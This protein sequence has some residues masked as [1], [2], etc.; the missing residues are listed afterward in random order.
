MTESNP[1]AKAEES[2]LVYSTSE[3]DADRYILINL[4]S[5]DEENNIG[6]SITTNGVGDEQ[7]LE[8][9]EKLAAQIREDRVDATPVSD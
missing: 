1:V 3:Q 6:V 2:G 9:L 4:L 8:I 7:V 5:K